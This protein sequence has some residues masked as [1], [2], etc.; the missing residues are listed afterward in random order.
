MNED[1]HKKRGRK[2]REMA[3]DEFLNQISAL[4]F[5]PSRLT[6]EHMI[7]GMRE[8]GIHNRSQYIAWALKNAHDFLV[9]EAL[10][11]ER[12]LASEEVQ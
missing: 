6:R 4:S 8:T 12:L 2:P 9:G 1:G 10:R 5:V 7:Y 11:R 3:A